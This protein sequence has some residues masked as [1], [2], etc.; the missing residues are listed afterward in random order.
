MKDK[1]EIFCKHFLPVKENLWRFCLSVA[2]DYEQAKD[3]LQDTII[4]SYENFEK[5]KNKQA[6]LSY[7]F[8][9]AS[10]LNQTRFRRRQREQ[11]LDEA[12]AESLPDRDPLPD[13]ILENED[14]HTALSKIPVDQREAIVLFN[15]MGFSRLEIC[16][17]QKVSMDTLKARLYRGRKKLAEI[18]S[19]DDDIKSNDSIKSNDNIKLNDDIR[20]SDNVRL[21]EYE[22]STGTMK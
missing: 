15:I 10:R 17:I 8:T 3:L 18:L 5:L 2:P 21:I 16:E 7:L 4:R 11:R 13:R 20:F 14:V 22:I 12:F 6:F 19:C 1:Q 9:I